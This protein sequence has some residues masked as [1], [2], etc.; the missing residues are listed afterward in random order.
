MKN[1]D[2]ILDNVHKHNK[3]IISV[4][5]GFLQIIGKKNYL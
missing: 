4:S 3:L 2:I 5:K 1:N